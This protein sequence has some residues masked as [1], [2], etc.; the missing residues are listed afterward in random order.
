MTKENE[1]N[2]K[3]LEPLVE[4]TSFHLR[5]RFKDLFSRHDFISNRFL[6]VEA[7]AGQGKSVFAAQLAGML[8]VPYAWY[9]IDDSDSDP[10]FFAVSLYRC[11]KDRFRGFHSPIF[12]RIA[13]EGE[14]SPKDLPHMAQTLAEGFRSR[15][16]FCPVLFFDDLHLLDTSLPGACFLSDFIGSVPSTVRFCLISREPTTA[17]LP[18]LKELASATV[19]GNGDLAFTRTEVAELFN[20]HLGLTIDRSEV[21]R[22]CDETEGWA[23]GIMLAAEAKKEGQS[24]WIAGP[25]PEDAG[26]YFADNVMSRLPGG[27]SESLMVLA[28]PDTI[29]AG[30][31]E[32]LLG[33]EEFSRFTD[34]FANKEHFV[35]FGKEGKRSIV[36]HHLFREALRALALENLG[37]ERVLGIHRKAALWME[38]GGFLAEALKHWLFAEEFSEADRLLSEAGPGHEASNIALHFG[39]VLVKLPVS[40]VEG[41]PWLLYYYGL[42]KLASGNREA[43]DI[44]ERSVSGFRKIGA[45]T[46]ELL[47]LT[48]LVHLYF[49]YNPDFDAL[50]GAVKRSD[51]LLPRCD[52]FLPAKLR[53]QIRCILVSAMVFLD[54][55]SEKIDRYGE[56]AMREAKKTRSPNILGWVRASKLTAL[57]LCARAVEAEA[58]FEHTWDFF[59]SPRVNNTVKGVLFSIRLNH[60]VFNGDLEEF[61]MDKAFSQECLG[62]EYVRS[63]HM[64]ALL[65]SWEASFPLSR[66]DYKAALELLG[67]MR[68]SPH[69]ERNP[70]LASLYLQWEGI[71]YA[72]MG[73][74]NEAGDCAERSKALRSRSAFPFF[75]AVNNLVV[76]EIKALLGEFDGVTRELTLARDDM[77]RLGQLQMASLASICL[78][79]VRLRTG[80]ESSAL[81]DL[82]EALTTARKAG[83]RQFPYCPP[84]IYLPMLELGVKYNIEAGFCRTMARRFLDKAILP[85]G[86]AIPLLHVRTLGRLELSVSGSGVGI[87]KM[88]RQKRLLLTALAVSPSHS[89][90]QDELSA[91]LW[92]DSGEEQ[93]RSSFD[94][95]LSRLRKLLKNEFGEVSKHYLVLE[96]GVLSL[97]NCYV[98]CGEF[99]D[100]AAAGL[101]N[102]RKRQ[103]VKGSDNLFRALALWGW[104]F[105]PGVKLDEELEG[106]RNQLLLTYSRA[107]V[108]LSKALAEVERYE[109]VIEITGFAQQLLPT[110]AELVKLLYDAATATK[111]TLLARRVL[112]GYRKSLRKEGFSDK[113][114]KEALD[115]FWE[116]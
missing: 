53:I 41:Y 114:V 46:G 96:K 20:G 36:Y 71:A 63:G 108:A 75:V 49:H 51:E 33:R 103:M 102:L 107:V 60:R 98:D 100:F 113:E 55:R 91:M 93:A 8:S 99:S 19:I 61:E 82:R 69:V 6:R 23:M 7:R 50:S 27:I 81:G 3:F 116:M 5:S 54:R 48:K 115:A 30:L 87:E 109:K 37:R 16:D 12:E 21:A 14:F 111:N 45:E 4:G 2:P 44:F 77:I 39:S 9:Q 15:V 38:A 73:M 43:L 40:A 104:P 89:R 32:H 92:P 85:D 80:G 24:G 62:R 67:S 31:P 56:E 72:L 57:V 95:L 76:A 66:G 29:P 52:T 18:Q 59:C 17:V 58:E 11:L 42:G 78:A 47:A 105:A 79:W 25:K 22:L 64:G 112:T 94:T 97:R 10:V 106:Y 101:D 68:N 90:S 34:A 110:D 35:S 84:A 83:Y 74:E 70:H 26:R 65:P 1:T 88:G 86:T 28:L 13:A